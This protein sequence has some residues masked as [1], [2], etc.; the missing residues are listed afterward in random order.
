MVTPLPSKPKRNT[1]VYMRCVELSTKKVEKSVASHPTIEQN[2][3][4]LTLPIHLRIKE[5]SSMRIYVRFSVLKIVLLKFENFSGKDHVIYA[6]YTSDFS[7]N[8]MEWHMHND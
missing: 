4:E 7:L 8:T 3:G 6:D 2:R 1:T 5:F